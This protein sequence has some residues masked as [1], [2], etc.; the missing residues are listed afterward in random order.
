MPQIKCSS[1]ASELNRKRYNDK[2]MLP[3]CTTRMIKAFFV[4]LLLPCLVG[5]DGEKPEL[6]H[7]VY[8]WQRA[9]QKSTDEAVQQIAPFVETFSVLAGEIEFS[10]GTPHI[11]Y[12]QLNYEVLGKTGKALVLCLRVGSWRGPFDEEHAVT[13]FIFKSANKI[14][15][16]ARASSAKVV[17]LQ[18]DFDCTAKNLA[19]YKLWLEQLRELCDGVNLSITVLPSWLNQSGF[20]DL[21]KEVD[22]F[23]LQVHSLLKSEEEGE[24]YTLCDVEDAVGWVVKA[25]KYRRPF[26][27]ALPTYGYQLYLDSSGKVLDVQ[28]E[29]PENE[30]RK[31]LK[32]EVV[33]ANYHDMAFLVNYWGK[34][35]PKWLTAISW[36]R[37]PV[38]ADRYNWPMAS[39]LTV[40]SGKIP[41][42][43]LQ[44]DLNVND[45]GLSY[46]WLENVG[47]TIVYQAGV[48]IN[49]EQE[50][51]ITAESLNGFGVSDTASGLIFSSNQKNEMS[52]R[53]GEKLNIG[54]F[55]SSL[56][57]KVTANININYEKI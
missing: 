27:V 2:C 4:T 1:D 53:P 16:D 51:F 24:K 28:A 7:D 46:V 36:Y 15:E 12:P 49:G 32:R 31:G 35:S 17:E 37:L 42:R 33:S 18:I 56:N 10:S 44:V 13:D 9:W 20:A 54:W 55:R 6:S 25:N 40:M 26:T 43:K 3:V 5:C 50:D 22:S 45:S 30:G 57:S 48:D 11:I 52:L 39:L 14:L 41:K 38:E 21:I 8:V 47:D 19:G 23:T 29:E 34:S